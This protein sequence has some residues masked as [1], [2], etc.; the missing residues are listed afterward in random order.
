MSNANQPPAQ[1]NTASPA[2]ALTALDPEQLQRRRARR[3][4]D[5][6][7]EIAPG[8]FALWLGPREMGH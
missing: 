5:G 6:E 2:R 4:F 3:L 1:N 7:R 8:A